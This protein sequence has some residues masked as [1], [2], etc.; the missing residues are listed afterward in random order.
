MSDI[1]AS[2]N[3]GE[4]SGA[5]G[6]KAAWTER[7]V[8]PALGRHPE[9]REQFQTTSG[10][11]VDRLY[12]RDD[13]AGLDHGRDLGYPGEFPF[14]RGI[15]PTMYRGRFWTMRQYAG[16]GTAEETN[17]RFKLL[18][19][20]GQTGLSTAFDLPTQMGYDSDHA[21]SAGEV[22]RVGVAIDT[23][24]DMRTLLDGIPLDRVSTSMT[25]NATASILLAFYVAVADER[26][27]D[28]SKLSGTIQNDIL[29]EY[30]ARG[31]YIFPVEPSLRLITDIFG[32][33]NAQVPRWNT[34][35]IS[36]YHIREAGATAAQEVAFTFANA[37]EYVKRALAAGLPIE[38]F[39]PRLSFFFASHN[40]LFEEVAKFRAARRLYARL[41]RERWGANDEGAKLRFHTQTGGVTLQAQQPLNNVVRVTVQALAAALGGTQSLHTNGYDEALSLPTAQA[42]TLALRTQQVLAYESGIADTVDP[43]AGSYYVESLTDALEAKAREYLDRIEEIGGASEA[44]AYMQEEI[45]RAAY[46]FQIA[47]ERGDKTI[48]GVNKFKGQD[49]PF[50]LGQPDF[51]AL[52]KGQRARL[53]DIRAR[54]DDAEVRARL[55]AIRAA[56][57]GTDNLMPLIIDAVKTMVTLGEISDALRAEWGVYRP[58]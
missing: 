21:M 58:A 44:I 14:T 27:I 49:E 40:D 8:T 34:I 5:V 28:R 1:L 23:V 54:R 53:A 52:E 47:V 39:A 17:T 48:V 55:E 22:G 20:A 3:L 41:M 56:A 4:D 38:R 35:S 24:D 10:V 57:R 15:Q 12:T 33:C 29:K 16:F 30:I 42:A 36:G 37:M 26:G 32:F 46:E 50:D 18:L 45:H 31:T 9:R 11:E 43:L 6:G 7:A 2:S 51:S 13:V 19:E 25:I